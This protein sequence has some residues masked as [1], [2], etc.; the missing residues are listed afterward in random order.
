VAGYCNLICC[1]NCR[2][3]FPAET[4]TPSLLKRLFRRKPVAAG[5]CGVI[6]LSQM[7]EGAQGELVSLNTTHA[8]RRNALAVFGLV[9]G[10]RLVLQQKSPAYVIRV[11]E[12][13]LALEPDIARE[14]LVRPL[15]TAAERG[16]GGG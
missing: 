4:Q 3:E 6:N 1:P 13:E 14:I 2:Y 16:A 12:T 10:C 7:A 9:P 8:S 11:G 5:K 15:T